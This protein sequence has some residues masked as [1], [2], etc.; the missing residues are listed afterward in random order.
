M[1][2]SAM[3]PLLFALSAV[4]ACAALGCGRPFT[5]ATPP[6]FVDLGD[7]R[8]P[9]DEYRATTAEGV[10]LG[11]RAFENE[12]KGDIGFWSKVI[13]NRM[14]ENGGYALLEKR[15]VKSRNGLPGKQL[16]FGHDEGRTPHLY[17]LSVFVDDDHV[18]LLE[19]GGTKEQVE[20][21]KEQIDW[22]V[23]NF[24]PD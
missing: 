8:Y 20:R 15:D 7:D 17:Y 11:V 6:G 10:V 1:M 2:R 3:R 16:R 9:D 24:L 13:E 12:P 18:Y 19:A 4:L 14:R 21:Q 23:R 5:A 22:S